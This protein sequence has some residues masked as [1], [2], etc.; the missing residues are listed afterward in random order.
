[1]RNLSTTL[2]LNAV[3]FKELSI[4]KSSDNTSD[5]TYCKNISIIGNVITGSLRLRNARNVLLANNIITYDINNSY[6]NQIVNNLFVYSPYY[7]SYS[8]ISGS[9]NNYIAN[10]I[11]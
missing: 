7:N 3:S 8:R 4:S 5:T 6:T 2:P 9:D 10:N 1:M 11:F